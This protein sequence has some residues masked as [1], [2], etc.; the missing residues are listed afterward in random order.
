LA[1]FEVVFF[2]V[3]FLVV[4]FFDAA[5]LVAALEADFFTV[6]F[7]L[8]FLAAGF[9]AAAF[10]VVEDFFAG[11]FEEAAFLV[12]FF[13]DFLDVEAFLANANPR[14]RLQRA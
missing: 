12:V 4:V 8:D 11:A 10:F 7:A 1:A 13:A 14:Q 9:F 5:L 3:D 6:F 2:C